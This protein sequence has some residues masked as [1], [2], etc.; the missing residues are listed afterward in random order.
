MQK[1]GGRALNDETDPPPPTPLS[2][3]PLSQRHERAHPR[4]CSQLS[5]RPSDLNTGPVFMGGGNW[6]WVI[7][8]SVY[9]HWIQQN[10][11]KQGIIAW[12]PAAAFIRTQV[13]FNHRVLTVL[14]IS[15]QINNSALARRDGGGGGVSLLSVSDR[16]KQR[17]IEEAVISPSITKGKY[18]L[19]IS[20]C[21]VWA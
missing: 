5:P 20:T 6:K 2:A 8:C 3:P 15:R 16:T 19:F 10:I 17:R 11:C 18:L 12:S 14:T 13:Y 1:W 9:R 21:L 4:A 7:Y